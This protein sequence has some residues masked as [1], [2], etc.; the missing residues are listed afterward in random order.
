MAI[1][2]FPEPGFNT[3][4]TVKSISGL[5]LPQWHLLRPVDTKDTT[6]PWQKHELAQAARGS[7]LSAIGGY[8]LGTFS[9]PPPY[10]NGLNNCA[11]DLGLLMFEN[12]NTIPSCHA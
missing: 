3:D 1:I 8:D 9:D 11:G 7:Y 4:A 2:L 5:S 10:G 12:R 6:D